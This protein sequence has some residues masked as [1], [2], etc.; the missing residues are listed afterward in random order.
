MISSCI[1]F[2]VNTTFTI[3]LI[4]KYTTSYCELMV[5]ENVVSFIFNF[6]EFVLWLKLWKYLSVYLTVAHFNFML[7]CVNKTFY[8]CIV[9]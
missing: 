1:C 2:Y 8:T 7:V 5:K 6:C 4:L 9:Y 3:S